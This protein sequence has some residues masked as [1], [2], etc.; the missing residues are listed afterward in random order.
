MSD[1]KNLTGVERSF[2]ADDLIVSK[3]DKTG[4]ITYANEVFIRLSGYQENELLGQPHSLIRHPEMPRA[5]FKLLWDT[6]ESGSEIFAYVVNRARNGDHYWVFAHVTPN[7]D[8]RGAIV[9]YHSSRRVAPPA[10]IS[11]IQ[12]VYQALLAE[13]RRHADRKAGLAASVAMLHQMVA[14]SGFDGY[15]RF[16]LSL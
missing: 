14:A 8:E 15:D 2:A 3:T 13:E 4:R 16:V 12:P 7:L 5:V 11:K 6:I 9:G 1:N 10:A